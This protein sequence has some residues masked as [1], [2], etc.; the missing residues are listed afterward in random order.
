MSLEI[1][2]LKKRLGTLLVAIGLLLGMGISAQAQRRWESGRRYDR[3]YG[4]VVSARRHERN[5]IRREL[6]RNRRYERRA[7][8]DGL[9]LERRS[10]RR[11]SDW[12]WRNNREWRH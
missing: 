8:N 5:E 2:T 9:R 1:N 11:N 10:E 3:S 7:L 6:R 12:R 4:M